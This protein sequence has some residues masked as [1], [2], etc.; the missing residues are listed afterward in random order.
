MLEFSENSCHYFVTTDDD[1]RLSAG[2]P[3]IDAGYNLAVPLAVIFD[4]EGNPR[5]VDHADTQDTGYGLP[6]VVDMGA[7]EFNNPLVAHWKL[8]EIDGNLAYDSSGNG[9]HGTLYDDPNWQPAG[10]KIA[11]SLEFDG[12][13]DYVETGYATNLSE[14]TIAA[15]VNSPAA[16]ASG[17]P[18]GPIHRENN[19][20][21]NWN[22]SSPGFEGSTALNV[23]SSWYVASF[24]PLE[25]D[26]WYHV[27]ATYDGE[28]LKAYKNGI[29]ITANSDPSGRARSRCCRNVMARRAGGY[30]L[31]QCRPRC[32]NGTNF[33]YIFRL[34]LG[35]Q[36][37]GTSRN[38]RLCPP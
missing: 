24:G 4:L 13:D 33:A 36:R 7:Y 2:S 16:P 19:Y 9:H 18:S 17:A 22:H 3:C 21:I 12:V 25:G 10:G 23:G 26:K 37:K 1:L 38:R 15:W 14:W 8:D 35:P 31:G 32:R 34:L 30:H 5:F 27:A 6:L 28:I 20:Q 29:L 11:G